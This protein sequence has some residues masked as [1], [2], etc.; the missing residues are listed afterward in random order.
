MRIKKKKINNKKIDIIR[1]LRLSGFT[2]EE[3]AKELRM[4]KQGV[5]YFIKTYNIDDDI[6]NEVINN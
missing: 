2:M 1:S 5:F 3:I 4:T 6:E